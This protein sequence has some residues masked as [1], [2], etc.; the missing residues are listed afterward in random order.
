LNITQI[1]EFCLIDLLAKNT[2]CDQSSVAVGIGDDAAAILPSPGKIELVT[3]DMLVETIHFDLRTTTP[4]Q[5]GRKAIAVN[6]SDIAAMGGTPKHALVSLALPPQTQVEFVLALYEGMKEICQEFQVNIIGGDTVASPDKL[7]LNVTVIGEAAN[8]V[9]RSGARA[10]DVV[11]VTGTLGDSAAGLELLLNNA[12]AKFSNSKVL[13]DAHLSPKPQVA[14]GQKLAAAGAA[15]MDDV[16]DG[17]AGEAHEIAA[18]SQVGLELY[19]DKIPLSQATIS[20]ARYFNKSP[21]AYALYGGEDFQLLFT[22]PPAIFADLL[23]TEAAHIC[24]I[25]TVM[26]GNSEVVL[27]HANGRKEKI[28]KKGYDHFSQTKG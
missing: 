25:G 1:G 22:M 27:I 16:S 3:A 23:K 18:A 15:S 5:L 8:L 12:A 28:T 11:A 6:L 4:R 24:Q 21:L 17:L 9:K 14:L 20:V 13:T 2:I 19:A 10:G 7:V 26:P